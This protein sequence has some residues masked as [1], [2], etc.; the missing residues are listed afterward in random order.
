MV[1]LAS[2]LSSITSSFGTDRAAAPGWASCRCS[3]PHRRRAPQDRQSRTSDFPCSGRTCR[4]CSGRGRSP[5]PGNGTRS[6]APVPPVWAS[7]SAVAH[8]AGWLAVVVVSLAA[9]LVVCSWRTLA[10]F[11]V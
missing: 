2:P 11:L 8:S 1:V 10:S 5:H 3:A 7:G 9:V 4:S 6:T